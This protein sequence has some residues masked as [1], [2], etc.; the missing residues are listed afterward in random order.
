MLIPVRK[1]VLAHNDAEAA[2]NAKLFE[3]RRVRVV[4]VMASPGAGKTSLI[5]ALAKRL[6]VGLQPLVIEGDVAS[7]IDT[8]KVAAA[9]IPVFQINTDGDCHLDAVSV[10]K[11]FEALPAVPEQ[12]L[13]FIENIGNLIC[14]AEFDL[15]EDIR[16]VIASVPEGDDKPRKYPA[17]F[18]L[19]DAIVL[20]KT[21]LAG[22]VE[23]DRPRFEAGV[24]AVNDRAPIFDVSCR[25]AM[26]GVD[27]LVDWLVV[28]R[29][30]ACPQ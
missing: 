25:G 11:A 7:S 27:A 8:E 17:I 14:P 23:F 10:R 6:P 16:L 13:L 29:E 4:N 3:S 9:G 5:L 24:R 1:A 28:K 18:A 21:D 2:E 30:T 12:G 20:N 22:H 26:A 15:G 19:A